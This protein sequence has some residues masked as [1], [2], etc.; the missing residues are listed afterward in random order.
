MAHCFRTQGPVATTTCSQGMVPR[1]VI[2]AVTAPE[3]SRSKPSFR[4]PKTS[5]TPS[6]STRAR[7][8][9]REAMLLA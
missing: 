4:T 6:A 7:R 5:R 1:S 8:P 2:T 9:S 3:A